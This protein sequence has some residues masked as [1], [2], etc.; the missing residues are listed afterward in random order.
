MGQCCKN[1]TQ[2][3]VKKFNLVG[4][5]CFIQLAIKDI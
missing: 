2:S 1:N 5:V 3:Y 4:Q